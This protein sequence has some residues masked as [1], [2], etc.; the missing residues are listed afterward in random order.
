MLLSLKLNSPL[1]EATEKVFC[2]ILNPLQARWFILFAKYVAKY[3]SMKGFVSGVEKK[4]VYLNPE[5]YLKFSSHSHSTGSS[6]S[7]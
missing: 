3:Y 4:T 7:S 1:P 5:K 6:C 2:L